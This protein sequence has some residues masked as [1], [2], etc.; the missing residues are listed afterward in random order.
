M[1][2]LQVLCLIAMAMLTFAAPCWAAV[3]ENF[4][5]APT[6]S[7]YVNWTYNG[8]H[9]DS[10]ICDTLGSGTCGG[11]LNKAVRL[12]NISTGTRY[13]QLEYVGADS[14]GKDGGVGVISFDYKSWNT[15]A[16]TFEV[17]YQVNG[18]A[19]V[20][21]GTT[22][23]AACAS[24]AHYSYTLNNSSDNIRVRVRRTPNSTTNER[25]HIDNFSITDFAPTAET[26]A[27]IQAGGAG[28]QP[29]ISSLLVT[30]PQKQVVLTFQ[31]HDAGT[32]T[33]NTIINSL[34]FSQGAGN[35]ASNWTQ[36]IAGAKLTDGTNTWTGTVNPADITF[37]GTPLTTLPNGGAWQGWSLSIWL[38]TTLPF[39]ADNKVLEFRVTPAS[40]TVDPSGSSF[41]PTDAAISSGATNN[42][43][44]IVATQLSITTQPPVIAFVNTNFLMRAG[45]TDIYGGIDND[46]NEAITL[47][48]NTGTG[49]L[50]AVSGLTKVSTNGE[51]AWSDLQYNTVEAGVVIQAV[52]PTYVTPVLAN[53]IT[54]TVPPTI[55][56]DAYPTC[57]DKD[58][59]NLAMAFTVHISISNWLAE[60]NHPVY[61]KVFNSTLGNPYHFTTT[62]G[63]SSLTNY[64]RKPQV[65]LDANGN[66]A[67]WLA[68]KSFG[69]AA[70]KPRAADVTNTGTNITGAEVIGTLLDL[71]CNGNGAVLEDRDASTRATPGD[72]VLIRNNSNVIVGDWIVEDNGYPLDEGASTIPNGGW[73]M[74]LCA[75]CEPATYETWRPDT[76]PGHGSPRAVDHKQ[77]FCIYPCESVEVQDV[78]LPVEL[79]GTPSA[80]AGDGSVTLNWITASENG[81]AR[82]D[83]L[84]GGAVVGRVDGAGTSPTRHTYRW[85][86][87][88]LTNGTTYT[89]TLR[90]VGVDGSS[91]E[92]AMLEATPFDAAAVTEYALHQNYPNPFN[93]TTSI[94]VDLLDKGNVS[95][96]VYNLMGQEVANLV[97]G[98][99]DKGR[100]LVTFDAS[101]L[102]S[103]IYLYRLSVNGFVAEKKMLLMK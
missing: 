91:F 34:A 88:G 58:T 76:W 21:L 102:S 27:H 56:I 35:Q 73:R 70:I 15:S 25:L 53:P 57:W 83:I 4:D 75:F 92:L 16:D 98:N 50:S 103:G 77:D 23:I 90:A 41:D 39:N 33:L 69:I 44:N 87:S 101:K 81:N 20:S 32:G 11:L 82:F 68:L 55:V 14:M 74:A 59:T 43:I 86:E 60:A 7:S 65:T 42:R 36:Y 67:G 97:N 37:S 18:G 8:F 12:R 9:A 79:L 31:V 94:A 100:H 84:R 64:D 40:F 96:K 38:K 45:F 3:S 51:S 1:K 19:Y 78:I 89:Y 48:V 52:S 22:R 54:V 17:A 49:T 63:W 13:A 28:A 24:Y 47:T 30:E 99:M 10:C 6:R 85:T 72:I 80:T 95:L 29:T 61:V 26:D 71:S 5:A 46:F 93:P 2:K 62:Y 66:W